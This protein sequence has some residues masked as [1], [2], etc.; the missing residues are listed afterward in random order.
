MTAT[1]LTLSSGKRQ[2]V[3]DPPWMNAAGMLGFSDEASRI[4]NLR[5]LGALITNPI[6]L[7]RRSPSSGERWML[8]PGG[9][10]L[11]TGLPNPGL[12]AAIAAHRTH[13]PALPCPCIAH[14]LAVTAAEIDAM[15]RRLES[16]EGI[17]ALEIGLQ[18]G[19]PSE[20]EALVSAAAGELPVIARLP[21]G[22]SP[23]LVEAALSAG[24]AALS[25]GPARGILAG[26]QPGTIPTEGRLYGP[27]MLPLALRHLASLR[28]LTDRPLIAAGGIYSTQD[29]RAAFELGANA[30][31]LDSVL[32]VNPEAVLDDDDGGK[33][34]TDVNRGSAPA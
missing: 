19:E 1:A 6:S 28:R 21:H 25:I 12:S 22:C 34:I 17:S 32:W 7:H 3:I 2:V 14:L 11:H 26:R 29:M 18:E 8:F 16:V 5:H 15:T 27:A 4:I 23:S 13:W 24:A 10:A 33:A 9:M 20:V 31:Q 30:V